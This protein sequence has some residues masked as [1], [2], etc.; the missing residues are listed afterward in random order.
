MCA[1]GRDAHLIT[2]NQTLKSVRVKNTFRP[3]KTELDHEALEYFFNSVNRLF[4][5]I[6]PDG[7]IR[8][9]NLSFRRFTGPSGAADDVRLTAFLEP[10]SAA[11]FDDLLANLPVARE[12]SSPLR[13]PG[14]LGSVA[15]SL[16]NLIAAP[17]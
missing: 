15:V 2:I 10:K 13:P 7:R 8:R 1:E 14:V 4:V 17:A 6:N 16:P 3:D 12:Q 11:R 5:V 9:A